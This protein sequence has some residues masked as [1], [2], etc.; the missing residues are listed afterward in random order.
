M[1]SNPDMRWSTTDP[2]LVATWLSA[3]ATKRTAMCYSCGSPD[4]MST[5]CPLRPAS[6]LTLRY[7]C[8]H[9]SKKVSHQTIKVYHAGIS[10]LHLEHGLKDPTK[11][12][13]LLSYLCT[14]IQRSS[15]KKTRTRLPIIIPLLH[16]SS[17]SCPPQLSQLR[18]SCSTGQPSPW[19]SIHPGLLWLPQSQQVLV[20]HQEEVQELLTPLPEHSIHLKRSKTDCFRKSATVLIGAT[21]SSTCP[22]RAMQKFLEARQ[23]Q[24]PGPLFRLSNGDLPHTEQHLHNDQGPPPRSGHRSRTLQQPQLPHQSCH[25]RS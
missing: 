22:V 18:T 10:L 23:C 25:C 19:P 12:T 5:D 16:A 13:P 2:E 4:H 24:P 3:D 15:R 14:G 11:D 20:P 6:E 7:F 17:G 1:A 9:L 8:A 21:G